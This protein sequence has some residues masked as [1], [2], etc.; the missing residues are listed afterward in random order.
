MEKIFI[1]SGE[2]SGDQTGA[3]YLNKIKKNIDIELKYGKN[4]EKVMT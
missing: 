1:V 3:W 4:K 2:L